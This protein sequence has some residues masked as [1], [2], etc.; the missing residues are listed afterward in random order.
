MTQDEKVLL[1]ILNRHAITSIQAIYRLG[2]TRLAAI[3]HKLERNGWRFN[4]EVILVK[5]RNRR[6]VHVTKYRL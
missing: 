2:V 6:N 5:D 4:H 1:Y 3:I